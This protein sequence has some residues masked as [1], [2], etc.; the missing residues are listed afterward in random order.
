M[1]HRMQ[2]KDLELILNYIEFRTNHEPHM[3]HG[4]V[5]G[6]IKVDIFKIFYY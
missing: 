1:P 2:G 6:V 5:Q 3:V 4:M